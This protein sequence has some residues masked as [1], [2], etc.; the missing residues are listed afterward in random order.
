MSSLPPAT[1]H[2][3]PQLHASTSTYYTQCSMYYL[4]AGPLYNTA[5]AVI[6]FWLRTKE[7]DRV[8]P[9]PL[10]GCQGDQCQFELFGLTHTV[11]ICHI[12]CMEYTSEQFATINIVEVRHNK[13]TLSYPGRNLGN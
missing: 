4:H 6:L 13:R 9:L 3:Y 8:T 12:P 5:K 11:Y 10:L 7:A 2:T 1:S